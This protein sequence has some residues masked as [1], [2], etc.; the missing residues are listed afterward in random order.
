MRVGWGFRVRIIGFARISAVLASS[1]MVSTFIIVV[2][3]VVFGGS[4][5]SIIRSLYGAKSSSI[6]SFSFAGLF[7]FLFL[8]LFNDVSYFHD[9]YCA[10]W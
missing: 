4:L 9:D 10:G 3:V 1:C 5:A 8:Q 7:L 6:C 2:S